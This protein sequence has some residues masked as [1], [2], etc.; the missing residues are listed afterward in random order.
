MKQ[1]ELREI[2]THQE[3]HFYHIMQIRFFFYSYVQ[4]FETAIKNKVDN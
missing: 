3:K 2:L 1:N 4:C